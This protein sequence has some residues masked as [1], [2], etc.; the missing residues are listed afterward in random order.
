MQSMNIS[1]KVNIILHNHWLTP[2]RWVQ[3]FLVQAEYWHDPFKNAEYVANS[4]FLAD[5]N[6]ERSINETYKKNLQQLD[7]LVLVLFQN[8]TIVQPKESEWF[9]YFKVGS[10]KEMISLENSTLYTEVYHCIFFFLN[11]ISVI[12]IFN[13]RIDLD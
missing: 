13:N 4:V 2:F 9:G 7:N 11:L 6:N 12:L 3:K 8:E 10:D 1:P 5:I